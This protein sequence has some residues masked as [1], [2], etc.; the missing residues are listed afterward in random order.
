[1]SKIP[2]FEEIIKDLFRRVS[3]LEKYGSTATGGGGVD[4]FKDLLDTPSS[5]VGQGGKAVVVN[6]GATALEFADNKLTDA[7]VETA[8]NNQVSVVSQAEAE[9]GTA[10]TVRRWTAER[11][12]QAILALGVGGSAVWGGITGTL[13]SQTDLQS[14]LD[15]KSN[16]GHTHTESDITDL[17]HYDSTDF[18]TDLATKTL[19]D[20]GAGTTNKHFT[21][22]DESKLDGIQAGAEVNAVD[23]VNAQTGAVVLDADDIDD[24]STTNKFT[25]AGD[26][27]KLA[28]IEAGADVTDTANVTSA[29]A[30]MDSEVDAN[31][32]TL[33][34]P[35]STTISAFGKTLVDDADA[36]T[37]RATLGVAK[38]TVSATE[39]SSPATNDLW[40]DIS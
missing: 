18:D 31:V 38:I 17:A 29:G 2:S 21:A 39:P 25:T 24:T 19:D 6:S 3:T 10:T 12:K 37:A 22:T 36:S 11:V 8:Y 28:G 32:K 34:L 14:A 20:V 33:V 23:S 4:E 40:V 15:G 27:S 16:T 26:I 13:S 1:M 7:E 35:A 5:Y 9:A 30:L